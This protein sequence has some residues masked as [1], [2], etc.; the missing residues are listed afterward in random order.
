MAKN[1]VMVM[2]VVFILIGIWGFFSDPV[3]GIFGVNMLHNIVHLASGI[4]AVIFAMRG[5]DS[6]RAFS[7]VFGLVY[8]LVAILGYVTPDLM[9]RLL[10]INGSDNLLHV[11]LAIVFLVIG[12]TGRRNA[13]QM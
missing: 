12:F 8:L 11:V 2:G 13:P 3:A 4:L 9:E 1:I 5:N 6:A 10:A 7:K